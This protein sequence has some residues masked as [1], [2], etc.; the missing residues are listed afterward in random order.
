MHSSPYPG[1]TG[2]TQTA[3]IGIADGSTNFEIILLK[4]LVRG[5]EKLGLHAK[6]F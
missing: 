4:S 3:L 2:L 6:G 5:E 1:Q